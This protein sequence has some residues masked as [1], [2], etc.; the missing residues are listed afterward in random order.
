LKPE[1]KAFDMSVLYLPV[2]GQTRW[3]SFENPTAKKGSAGFENHGAK[4][5]AFDTIPAGETITMLDY[6]EGAGVI[7]RIWLTVRDRSPYMLRSLVIRCWWD[8]AGKPAVEAPLG[9]FFSCGS[10]ICAFENE[11]FSSPEGKSF[12]SYIPMPFKKSA[13]ITVTNESD[14]NLSHFFYDVNLIALNEP[15]PDALYFHSYWKREKETV[16]GEDYVILPK[17]EGMG[18]IIGAAFV[19]NANPAYKKQ[20]W[21]EG[22]VKAYIDGDTDLPTLCGTGTEDYIG[23]GWGQG[24]FCNRYQG[25]LMSDWETRKWVFYRLHTVDPMIFNR[26]INVT[27]QIMGGAEHYE[28]KELM[29][30]GVPLIPVTNDDPEGVGFD[31]LYKTDKPF[32]EKGWVNYYRSDDMASIVWFYLDKNENPLPAIAPVFERV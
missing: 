24:V 8:G 17:L 16:L 25:C 20:W 6:S 14:R 4:G 12:N 32:P 23:T 22:E 2:K 18:H 27:I 21:G 10:E 11:L 1:K 30:E 3:S 31:F 19:M 26:E 9:D 5:H 28:V 7:K 13:R 15:E 29:D